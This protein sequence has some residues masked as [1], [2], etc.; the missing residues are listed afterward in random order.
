MKLTPGPVI[1]F[2]DFF[3]EIL[4]LWFGVIVHRL[5]RLSRVLMLI[6][7]LPIPTLLSVF[8]SINNGDCFFFILLVIVEIS[9]SV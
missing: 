8:F 3:I 7:V 4:I 6:N 5:L 9:P 1:I 2:E